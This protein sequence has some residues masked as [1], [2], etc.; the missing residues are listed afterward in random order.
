MAAVATLLFI[1]S[2]EKRQGQ[3]DYQILTHTMWYEA[4][5]PADGL[6]TGR[7]YRFDEGGMVSIYSLAGN[8]ALLSGEYHYIFTPEEELLAIESVGAFLVEDIDV[9]EISLEDMESG[10]PFRLTKYTEEIDLP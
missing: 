2:C 10:E 8:S 1:C 5:D 9:R 3:V 4:P 7:L 6:I